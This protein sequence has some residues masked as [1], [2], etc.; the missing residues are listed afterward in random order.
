MLW[1]LIDPK[2]GVNA[3]PVPKNN[4][5]IFDVAPWIE[6]CYNLYNNKISI[7]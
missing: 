2:Y 1:E 5:L 7:S 6:F 3:T 4:F